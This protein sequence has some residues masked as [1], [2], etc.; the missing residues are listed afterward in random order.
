MGDEHEKNINKKN[1]GT[2]SRG[3]NIFTV[4]SAELLKTVSSYITDSSCNYDIYINPV[5]GSTNQNY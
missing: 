2:Q 4:K 1:D 3:V 5:S